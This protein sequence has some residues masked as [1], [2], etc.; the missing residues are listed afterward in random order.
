MVKTKRY[1]S[2]ALTKAINMACN[3]YIKK[4]KYKVTLFNFEKAINI[5]DNMEKKDWDSLPTL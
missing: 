4:N 2:R 3:E 1:S 5:I